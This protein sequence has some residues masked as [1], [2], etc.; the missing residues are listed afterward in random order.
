MAKHSVEQDH[1]VQQLINSLREL[2]GVDAKG[3]ADAEIHVNVAGK[4]VKLVVE[5]KMAFHQLK[6]FVTSAVLMM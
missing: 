1:L 4:A 2:P 6:C 3:E 5:A